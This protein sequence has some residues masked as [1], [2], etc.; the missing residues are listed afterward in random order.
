MVER[1]WTTKRNFLGRRGAVQTE[2][3][4]F[5]ARG[6]ILGE[7]MWDFNV[8]GSYGGTDYRDERHLTAL[9]D[10]DSGAFPS[11]WSAYKPLVRVKAAA[12]VVGYEGLSGS[13]GFRD[14]LP[15]AT[16]VRRIVEPA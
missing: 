4:S 6:W 11:D 14:W 10:L 16:G 8:W 15:A 13:Q 1:R 7:L 3:S 5:Q 2:A 9:L 12:S